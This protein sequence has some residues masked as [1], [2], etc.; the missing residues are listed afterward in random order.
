[1]GF[2][3]RRVTRDLNARVERV[4]ATLTL[5]AISVLVVAPAPRTA[6]ATAS[7]LIAAYGFNEGSGTTTADATGNGHTGTL[8]GATWTTAGKYGGALSFNGSTSYVDLGNA[9][10]LQTTGSMTWS[11]WI[12]ATSNPPDDGQIIAKSNGAGWQLKT[13]PDTG[14]HTFGVGVSPTSSSLTQRYSTTVRALNTWYHVAGVYDATARTLNIY[15][16]GAL[17]N[18]VLSGTVPASQF[19]AASENVTIGRRTGG[20]YFAGTIDEVR[21]YNRALSQTEIQSDMNTPIGGAP[22]PADT[23][24]P[25]TP[26]GLT[27]T[28]ASASQINLAWT[29]S[30]DDVAVT[31]YQIERCQGAG[32]TTFTQIATTTATSYGDTG[33]ASSTPYSYRVRATDAAGNLSAYSNIASATTQAPPAASSNPLISRGLST[34][35]SP[36]AFTPSATINDGN[37]GSNGTWDVP[38]TVRPAWV[39]IRVPAGPT[40][41]LLSWVTTANFDWNLV[42]EPN[43]GAPGDYTIA[44]ST[45]STDG[46]NGTWTTAATVTG[47]LYSDREHR[48]AFPPAGAWVK[49][50][51]T[52]MPNSSGVATQNGGELGLSEIDLH[53]ATSGTNDTWLFLGDSITAFWADRSNQPSFAQI[54]HN[55]HP[56]FFPM[57]INGGHGGWGAAELVQFLPSFMTINPDVHFVALSYGTNDSAG[58][59]AD[60]TSFKS[61]LQQAVTTLLNAGKVPVIPHIP[62][63]C[64]GQHNNIPLFN[65]AIDQVV[66]A[67]PGALAGPDLYTYFQSHTAELSDCLHPNPTGS[68]SFNRLWAQ[69]MDGLYR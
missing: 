47:N 13:T 38:G 41:L 4:V 26:S 50:T 46:I 56:A 67:N 58:N 16:N 3:E 5:V 53:D 23:I 6:A 29:A 45:D 14:Q 54:I 17:D 61:N 2:S 9:A 64:D 65:Q 59:N 24:P 69:A 68:L 30:T 34:A 40:K 60:T 37:Y 11:A 44:T 10:D 21:L 15:V 49:M 28:A 35:G 57:M 52:A 51:V 19:N 63:S 33:L 39:A 7:G 62:Y 8:Q 12:F 18:G 48:F 66:A 27:A 42:N 20:F 36:G 25:T 31:G 32:C 1:M 22:P 55:N 43:Y